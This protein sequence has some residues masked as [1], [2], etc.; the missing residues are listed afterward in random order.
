[1]VGI[2]KITNKINNKVYIG[3]SKSIFHRFN[4]HVLAL[5]KG[6]HENDLLQKDFLEHGCINFIFEIVELCNE[7]ELIELE[8]KYIN[9]LNDND[10][11][12]S[13]TNIKKKFKKYEIKDSSPYKADQIRILISPELKK[14]FQSICNANCINMSKLMHN[15]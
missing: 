11:N 10:Y 2:Y 14:A 8:S 7:N 15:L 13:R 1:M 6:I 5:N 9:K 12:I 4:N 3:Q